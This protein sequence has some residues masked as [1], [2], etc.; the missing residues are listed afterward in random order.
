MTCDGI[1]NGM[2]RETGGSLL[3]IDERRAALRRA[4]TVC[5]VAGAAVAL[6]LSFAHAQAESAGGRAARENRE[7]VERLLRA[8][9]QEQ[10]AR[11]RPVLSED[12]AAAEQ[13][14]SGET[15]FV[16][17]IVVNTPEMLP[18]PVVS[19]I[20]ARYENRHLTLTQI[21]RIAGDFD[22][23]YAEAGFKAG[24][25]VIPNQSLDQGEL[26]IILV[27]PRVD[28]IAVSGL[29][30]LDPD[31]IVGR[32]PLRPGEPLD[33]SRL[34]RNL[35]LINR[36]TRSG[37]QVEALLQPG[38]TFGTTQV[39]V[40][41]REPAPLE[42]IA[43]VDNY[44]VEGTGEWRPLT[45][46]RVNNLTGRDD[47]LQFGLSGARDSRNAFA[48]YST[49]IVDFVRLNLI[50]SISESKTTRGDLAELGLETEAKFAGASLE[51]PLLTTERWLL[52]G[53]F[54]GE[55]QRAT[56][57]SGPL[58]IDR[59]IADVFAQIGLSYYGDTGGVI[60]SLR[61][62]GFEA[63]IK[64]NADASSDWYSYVLASLFAYQRWDRFE[65]RLRGEGQWT[66]DDLLP[67]AKQFSLGGAHSVRGYESSRFSGDSGFYLGLEG[68]F[69]LYR[70]GDPSTINA[71]TAVA[72]ADGGG[73]FPYRDDGSGSKREDFATSVGAGL[74]LSAFDSRLAMFAGVAMPLDT[75]HRPIHRD[76]PR[77][78]F[79]V[80]FTQPF[81]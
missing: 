6:P 79:S 74:E 55:Y 25:A 42:V 81:H 53:E 49:P 16:R 72:F 3:A 12:E 21:R 37:L 73:V 27:E 69:D 45:V 38:A 59:R 23:A 63:R 65:V 64:D 11:G 43:A 54:G 78:L 67:S 7:L 14:D 46:L 40:A 35:N 39:G 33:L 80:S 61:F 76:E 41:V 58:L 57:I 18:A 50:G 2:P 36:M 60:S 22:A 34:E 13:P 47:T 70:S 5:L 17:T 29:D 24:F 10:L 75:V 71:V 62:G 28:S 20:V 51:F 9:P 19:G 48:S 4:M 56:T 31:Y 32:I 52:K 77:L 66:P 8:E 68:R 44:G 30:R 26:R 15:Y 1:V